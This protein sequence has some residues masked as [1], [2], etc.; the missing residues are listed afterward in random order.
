MATATAI[1]VSIQPST[2][3][4]RKQPQ[5]QQQQQKQ[6]QQQH[7]HHHQRQKRHHQ[8]F[9]HLLAIYSGYSGGFLAATS[10]GLAKV[11][12]GQPQLDGLAG[13]GSIAC[14]CTLSGCMLDTELR[15]LEAGS[16]S[17][18]RQLH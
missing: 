10:S 8:T 6:Q 17:H 9:R 7:Y 4:N 2:G 3:V 11:E 16:G 15:Q 5:Q 14:G 13:P 1:T 12:A 18:A